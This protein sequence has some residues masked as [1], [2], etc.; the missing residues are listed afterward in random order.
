MTRPIRSGVWSASQNDETAGRAGLSRLKEGYAKPMRGLRGL[1]APLPRNDS[2]RDARGTTALALAMP[3]LA[4]VQQGIL[5][6][7]PF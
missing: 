3:P 6:C 4:P 7:S 1:S 5:G 2:S